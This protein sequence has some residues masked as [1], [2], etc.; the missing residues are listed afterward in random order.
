M[1]CCVITSPTKRA[2]A[3]G[4]ISHL[5]RELL[6]KI[7]KRAGTGAVDRG[8]E[9]SNPCVA[10]AEDMPFQLQTEVLIQSTSSWDGTPYVSYPAGRPQI[11]ILKITIAPHTTM[12]WHSHPLP[13]AGYI[14][15]GELTIEQEDGTK[16]HF[17][18]GQAVTETVNS[19]HRGITGAERTVLIVFYPGTPGLP[20]SL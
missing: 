10:Q 17:V 20:L 2:R 12:K 9:T 11:T 4:L 1:S 19:I 15:S 13:N 5:G 3:I 6:A 8:G 18:A 14:L 16:E 7:L